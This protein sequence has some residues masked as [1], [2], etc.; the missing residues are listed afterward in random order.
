MTPS[1]EV[2]SRQMPIEKKR[3]VKRTGLSGDHPKSNDLEKEVPYELEVEV[4]V[5]VLQQHV[6]DD[7]DDAEHD[8]AKYEIEAVVATG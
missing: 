3:T 5:D 8:D 7:L 1:G 4:E 2:Q 6:E